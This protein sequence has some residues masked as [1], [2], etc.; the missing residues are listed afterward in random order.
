MNKQTF[1]SYCE[2]G[3]KDDAKDWIIISC[4]ESEKV[5]LFYVSTIVYLRHSIRV[6]VWYKNVVS[7]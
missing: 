7:D 6:T 5:H 2:T 3:L 1:Y 4:D